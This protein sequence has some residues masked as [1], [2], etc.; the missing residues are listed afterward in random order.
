MMK[1]TAAAVLVGVIILLTILL[2]LCFIAIF[3]LL[4]FSEPIDE[5][6]NVYDRTDRKSTNN[7][8]NKLIG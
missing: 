7:S 2:I 8:D 1:I 4:H 6:N 5:T 3:F